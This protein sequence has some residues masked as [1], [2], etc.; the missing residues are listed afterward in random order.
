MRVHFRVCCGENDGKG[1]IA[2]WLDRTN[3]V[4][5]NQCNWYNDKAE[6]EPRSFD[7]LEKHQKNYMNHDKGI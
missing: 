7:R 3:F 1:G 4:V 6:E 5:R 2:G